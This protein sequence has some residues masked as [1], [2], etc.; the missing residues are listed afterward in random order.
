MGVKARPGL[1]ALWQ[2]MR[3]V[4]PS[5]RLEGLLLDFYAPFIS[6]AEYLETLAS[7]AR[8]MADA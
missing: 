6:E 3:D 2:E 5:E 8:E 1:L 4:A 7:V